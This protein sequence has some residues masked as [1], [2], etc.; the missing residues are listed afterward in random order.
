MTIVNAFTN[1]ADG[2]LLAALVV[3]SMAVGA[4]ASEGW[5]A[6]DKLAAQKKGWEQHR[7]RKIAGPRMSAAIRNAYEQEK[8][9]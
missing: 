2:S 4:I 9:P 6:L 1:V 3:G 8:R 5:R 7:S